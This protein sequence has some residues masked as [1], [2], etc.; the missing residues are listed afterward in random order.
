MF[1]IVHKSRLSKD[2]NLY[3]IE[4]PEIADAHLPGQFVVRRICE[5]GERIPVTVADVVPGAATVIWATGERKC[6]AQ[7]IHDFVMRTENR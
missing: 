4:A 6:A 7:G 3:E 1:R 2:I 5:E